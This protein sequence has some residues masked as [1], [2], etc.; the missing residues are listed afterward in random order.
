MTREKNTNL[1]WKKIFSELFT[2]ILKLYEITNKDI[3]EKL[4]IS[5]S[6][7]RYWRIGRNLPQDSLFKSLISFLLDCIKDDAKKFQFFDQKAKELFTQAGQKATYS[8]ILRTNPL[9]KKFICEILSICYSFAKS[10]FTFFRDK[11]AQ[12]LE[13]SI[14]T[15]AVIFDF[16]GTLTAGESKD[17]TWE[18]IWIELGYDKTECKNLHKKFN[19]NEITHEEWCKQT[20]I[21]FCAKHLHRLT[22]E[23]VAKRIHLIKGVKQTF[24]ELKKRDI[25]IYIVSGS[26]G[27]VI[28][29][30]LNNLKKYVESTMANIFVYDAGSGF[31]KEINGTKFDF[32]GKADFIKQVAKDLKIKPEEILFIG[33]SINDKFARSSRAR[34][35]CINPILTDPSDSTVWDNYIELCKDLTEILPYT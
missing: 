31:L 18:K 7:I 8:Q 20:E 25:K 2:S 1:E 10:D 9:Q 27:T 26:I 15:R 16:D 3:A 28:E 32:E 14:I 12:S 6:T 17:T 11:R 19:D 30:V 34:T 33:N 21:M 35:L 29:V 13:R 22:V 23:K 24:D 4:G 5:E